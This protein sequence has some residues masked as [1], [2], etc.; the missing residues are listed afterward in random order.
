MSKDV[1]TFSRPYSFL[2]RIRLCQD[3]HIYQFT[4][5]CAQATQLHYATYMMKMLYV[6]PHWLVLLVP[7]ID[8]R[9]WSPTVGLHT[10][11]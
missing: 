11:W 3:F 5:S 6:L 4:S 10:S 2:L 1:A 8:Q 9:K 7:L